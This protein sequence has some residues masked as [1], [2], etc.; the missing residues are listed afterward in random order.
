MRYVS[1]P[2]REASEA[3]YLRDHFGRD[4]EPHGTLSIAPTARLSTAGVDV[5]DE[6]DEA[7]LI[8]AE[9]AAWAFLSP[10]EVAIW[11]RLDGAM[12]ADVVG[13]FGGA[14]N[15]ALDFVA[16]LYRRGLLA[17]E[18]K[19]AVDERMFA[20]D[21][22]G[23]PGTGAN[24]NE[25]HLVELLLTEKCNL[26]CPY[27]LAGAGPSMPSMDLAMVTRTI[28][29]AF[30]MEADTLAFEFAGGE[31]FLKY[32]L[33]QQ[34]VEYIQQHPAYGSRR[35]FLSAQTNATLLDAERVQWIADNDIRLGISIDGGSYA[36]NRSRPMRNGKGS[37]SALMTGI[38]LL[39]DAGVSF[40]GL[41]VLNRSNVANPGELVDFM[42]D[43]KIY[44]FRINPIGFLGD[45]R[46]N[47]DTVGISQEEVVEFF[48]VLIDE[49][50][51]RG[52]PVLEDNLHTM[53]DFLTSKQR[54]TR[55]MR[56]ACGAGDTF[57]AITANG[58][59]YPCGRA[60][61]SPGLKLGN[62]FD[63]DVEALDQ[64]A[65]ANVQMVELRR[66]RPANFD[67]CASCSV[68]QLC[69]SGCSAQAWERFGTVRHK[70]PE[71]HFYKTMYTWLMHRV[72]FDDQAFAHLESMTYFN[73][74]GML[75]SHDYASV[76]ALA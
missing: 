8:H 36:Q 71:C 61:Q 70:T 33:M 26:A 54:R 76:L 39:Q 62:V 50:V 66:R 11:Q 42:L 32:R 46:K 64:P 4:Y 24:Y 12:Y 74:E 52:L 3:P 72:C 67:D 14:D 19:R 44:G 1:R 38:G 10:G 43:H 16:Q 53:F 17:I 51:D 65:V 40:G 13:E 35:V 15:V 45:A 75:F 37:F 22:L 41:V 18:G 58:D 23:R 2:M 21:F 5:L 31:P 56:S 28:D 6:Q 68:R 27:C 48:K 25:G 60:T 49:I 73:G 59:I 63:D 55:C 7:L 9:S 69:Q 20:D 30:A 57:Q 34:A 47:W 29:L